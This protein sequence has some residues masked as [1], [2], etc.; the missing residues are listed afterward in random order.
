MEELLKF[1]PIVLFL[2]YKLFG[3]S[4]KKEQKP[5][6]RPK[7]TKRNVPSQSTP[8]LE[9]ILRELSGEKPPSKQVV[10]S[11]ESV[12]ETLAQERKREQLEIGDHPYDVRPE[13]EHRTDVDTDTSE[14][15]STITKVQG[16]TEEEQNVTSAEFN[17]RQAVIAQVILARP[18]Y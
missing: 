15:R 8:S 17:L 11:P 9:E 1:I 3:G 4:K 10:P 7:P 13:Y 5:N 18:D 14:L 2:V 6:S 12:R 16:L